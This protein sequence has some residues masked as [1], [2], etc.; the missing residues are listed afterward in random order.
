ML[1]SLQ[2]DTESVLW[3]WVH[4]AVV[5]LLLKNI[6]AVLDITPTSVD[7][8]AN[9]QNLR[10]KDQD[11][12]GNAKNLEI[13]IAENFDTY[14]CDKTKGAVEDSV[15]NLAKT[16]KTKRTSDKDEGA[17]M[18]SS[19]D[20]KC[21]KHLGNVGTVFTN[22]NFSVKLFNN[23][24]CRFQ[25]TGP[26]SQIV[27]TRTLEVANVGTSAQINDFTAK[28]KLNQSQ[29]SIV[30]MQTDLITNGSA[31]EKY[32]MLKGN[33]NI[34]EVPHDSKDIVK[35]TKWW[36]TYYRDENASKIHEQQNSVWGHLAGVL[37]P[38]ELPP[39]C[40]LGLTVTDP[41]LQLPTKKGKTYPDIEGNV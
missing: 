2:G 26:L 15:D 21:R 25:L 23:E 36:Q 18:N 30:D 9:K 39:H 17:K 11:D 41:R 27:L 4:P 10:T 13:N 3:M 38:A 37:S 1:F 33:E 7:V 6:L 32:S 5:N 35:G 34:L 20:M 14:T 22:S 12:H 40:V 24:L 31:T 28:G 29:D 8:N 19:E 16:T